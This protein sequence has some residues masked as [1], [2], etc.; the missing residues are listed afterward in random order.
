M[1]LSMLWNLNATAPPA[2]GTAMESPLAAAATGGLYALSLPWPSP[3]VVPQ[4]YLFNSGEAYAGVPA[5]SS[6]KLAP[7]VP[8]YPVT[9]L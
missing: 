2:A 5:T 1:F 4:S 8:L 6:V 7:T 3:Q 9:Y